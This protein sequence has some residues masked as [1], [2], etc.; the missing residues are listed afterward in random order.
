MKALNI[1]LELDILKNVKLFVGA[2][3]EPLVLKG[4]AR[5]TTAFQLHTVKSSN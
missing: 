1:D 5:E 3:V 2:L 4:L